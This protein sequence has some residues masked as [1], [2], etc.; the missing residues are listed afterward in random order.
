MIVESR[1]PGEGPVKLGLRTKGR[2]GGRYRRRVG[3]G[4]RRCVPL[5]ALADLAQGG[6]PERAR[7]AAMSLTRSGQEE[8]AIGALLFDIMILF[9]RGDRERL[10]S[11]T[12]ALELNEWGERPWVDL[13]KGK[14][15]TKLW[16]ARQLRPYGLR[17]KTMWI[18]EEL[19]KGYFREDFDDV[20]RRYIPRKE[21]KAML[22]EITVSAE[23]PGGKSPGPA[24]GEGN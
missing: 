12:L 6:W 1:G 11:R 19:A 17:P 13:K 18:G 5:L 15:V 16:L 22:E 3:R 7:K 9:M 20:F 8:G 14:D 10:F 24:V 2:R 23:R 21:A 4:M